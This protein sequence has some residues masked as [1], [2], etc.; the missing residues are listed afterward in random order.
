MAPAATLL[1]ANT[2]PLLL[3]QQPSLGKRLGELFR[4]NDMTK[5]SEEAT[6]QGT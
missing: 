6:R 2:P 3:A 4:Q 5:K 1:D